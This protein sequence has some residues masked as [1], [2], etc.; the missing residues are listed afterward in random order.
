MKKV[1]SVFL[2]VVM[3]FSVFAVTAAAAT[4]AKVK[5]P[6]I[7]IAGSS[8]DLFD[9]EGNEVSTGIE[10]LT[11]DDEGD[12]MG[13]DKIVETTVNILKPFVMEGLLQDKW[14]NYGKVLYDEFA[15]IWDESQLDGDGNTSFDI[16]QNVGEVPGDGIGRPERQ[17]R[18]D[19]D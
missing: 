18:Y 17:R 1:I 8:V 3:V 10:V 11:D 12:G 9:A 2:A 4:N 16:G 7:F 19:G 15:P 14:D 13:M 6:I 5:Y